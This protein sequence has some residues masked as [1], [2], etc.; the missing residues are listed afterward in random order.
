MINK[1]EPYLSTY[2][3]RKGRQL[4]LPISGNF[5]LTARC[6][7]NCPMCYVHQTEEQI[8]CSGQK[9]LTAAQWL[10]L[11]RE[12][13]DRGMIFALLTGGEPLMRKDFFEIYDG[14]KK[15]GLLISVN[16]NGSMLQGEI[17]KRFLKDPPL[18]FNI[19]LYGGSNETYTKMCGLPMYDRV[20]ANIRA[21]REAGVS[22]SLNL[23]ATPYNC[24]DLEQIYK[25]AKE[26][27][28][29]VR[30][31]F[32]MYPPIR[33]NGEIYGQSNRFTEP[34]SAKYAALWDRLRFSEEEFLQRQ[35]N[36]QSL[37]RAENAACPLEEGEGVRCRAGSSS[38]WMTW[39]GRMMPCGMMTQ[40]VAYPLE[41]GFEAAWEQIRAETQKIRLPVKCQQCAYKEICGVCAAICYAETGRF[42]GVP[43]YLCRKAQETV[44]FSRAWSGKENKNDY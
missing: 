10:E 20:K 16:T 15:L 8:A 42:D 39:D 37:L 28:V 2:F 22:V 9:E 17:L 44:R 19:S 26:L 30:A 34:E 24:G 40:P 25:D 43:E 27:D 11:A 13:R 38:F 12:A 29:N 4:G 21:L 18:R 36:I 1:S 33:I 23:S 7:F 35:N 5:E 6:N 31:A 3:H 14:M 32:Y 41:V